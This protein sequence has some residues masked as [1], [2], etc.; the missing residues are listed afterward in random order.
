MSRRVTILCW[1]LTALPAGCE[2]DQPTGPG[3]KVTIREHAWRVELAMTHGERYQGLSGR[4]TLS[5][6]QGMLFV[7]PRAQVLEFCMRDCEI[8]IDI[9]Y[10]D[11]DRRVVKMHTMRME[12][13]RAGQVQ[14]SS[15]KPAQYAL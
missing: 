4:E 6:H 14:Y 15:Q 2:R 12:A 7:Y 13:D 10:L 8:D 11:A 3:P 1:L 9:A 5:E